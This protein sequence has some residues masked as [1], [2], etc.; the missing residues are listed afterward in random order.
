MV[1][2]WFNRDMEP[3]DIRRKVLNALIDRDG[4]TSISKRTGKSPQ[5]LSDTAAGRKSFGEK[6]ARDIESK[7]GLALPEKWLDS[8]QSIEKLGGVLDCNVTTGPEVKGML[9]LISWV[10][11]GEFCDVI[12]NF[13]P[14]DAEAWFPCP[15]THGPNA[16]ILRVNGESMSPEY[17]DGELIFIDQRGHYNHGDD[18]IVRTADNKATFKRLQV[19]EEGTFLL[20]LNPGWPD[21]IIKIPP[22][23]QICGKVIFQGRPR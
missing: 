6:V 4:L 1:T 12:D 8:L 13:Q 11:A 22:E 19:T 20:A 2:I 5:Q 16:Y 7:L 10:K 3:A 21:R 14:G 23:S 18:V 9:P 15:V 17:R